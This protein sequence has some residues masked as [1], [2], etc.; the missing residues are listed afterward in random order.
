[1]KIGVLKEIKPHEYRVG[2]TPAGAETL[3]KQGHTVLV[4]STAGMGVGFIDEQYSGA[5]AN[6]VNREQIFKD[7]ELILK[8]KEPTK[9]EYTKLKPG[10]VLFCYLHLAPDPAQ[11]KGLL[12]ADCIAF[13]Y[14]TVTDNYGRLPLLRPMSEIAGRISI[15]AG[16]HSLEKHSFGSGVLL[17][18]ATGVPPGKVVVIGGGVV[19]LNAAR[20]ANGMGG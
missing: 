16:A 4:E 2:L 5:G 15:Q 18:G 3:S 19:G 9:V 13:A 6:I 20:I 11:T 12:E 1:M 14:E 10:Q 7:A 17:S 8:V